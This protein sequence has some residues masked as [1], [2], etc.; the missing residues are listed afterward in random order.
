MSY[1]LTD[2][3]QGNDAKLISCTEALLAMDRDNALVPHSIGSHGRSLLNA[4]ASRLQVMAKVMEHVDPATVPG[5]T[6]AERASLAQY[7][8]PVTSSAEV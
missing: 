7:A 5:L 8:K 3:F 2:D 4:L 6:M 1:T